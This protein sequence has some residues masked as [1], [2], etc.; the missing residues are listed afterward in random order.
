[1]ATILVPGLLL[2]SF[3]LRALI[4]ERRLADQQIHEKLAAAAEGAARRLEFELLEWQQAA[5]RLAQSDVTNTARWPARVRA[6]VE[7]PGSAVVLSGDRRRAQALP[8]GHLLYSLSPAAVGP[9]RQP[10]SLL[11]EA[12]SRELREQNYEQ[13]VTLYRRAL[14][15]AKLPDRVV[16]LHRLARSLKKAGR[17]EEAVQV[18]R[19][20]TKEPPAR[21]GSLPSDLLALY[22]ISLL[23]R[24]ASARLEL[25]RNLVNGRWQLE[26]SSYF[27]YSQAVREILPRNEEVAQLEQMEQRK[28]ALSLAAERFLEDPRPLFFDQERYCLAFWRPEPFAAVLLAEP[29]LR[30]HLWPSVFKSAGNEDLQF[31]LLGPGGH[32]LFGEA[33]R[34]PLVTQS[35]EAAEIPLRLQV[36]PKNPA[37]L[38]ADARRRQG[39]YMG[40]L[41]GVIALLLFGGYFTVRTLRSELA[42]A[43]IKSDFVSTVSHEFRSPLA[44]INQ[45]GEMLRDGRVKDERTRQRY[46]EMIV[47]ETQ[48]LRRLVDNVLDFSRMEEGRKRYRFEPFEP[49]PW[50]RQIAEDFQEE[51]ASAGFHLQAT[52]PED[53]PV[54]VGDREALTTAVHNLLDNSA[55]YSR[56]SKT[57]WLE[58]SANGDGLTVTIRDRGVGISEQDKPHIFEKF[59]RGVGD[60]R[61][62]VKGVGL[63][64]NLVRHIVAAHGGTVDFESQEGEGSAFTLHLKAGT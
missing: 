23:E 24:Q 18:F 36:W 34:E 1:M 43:Q 35:L 60:L 31:S 56:D 13:A 44:G 38:Y 20:L 29:F 4:Q 54:L 40:L 3:G 21:I 10:S 46:Y 51:V 26:K 22:E 6:A 63:G 14:A 27:F 19:L 37:A 39:L 17:N 8:P 2:S 62:Q 25:Y 50:L 53:L 64:L 61:Q 7:E 58:A 47:R 42:V 45:L 52:V 55:K 28:L 5:D 12:E 57:V 15:S 33:G 59:Y 48:R 11:A 49:A 32:L 30:S 9:T 16:L 41:G